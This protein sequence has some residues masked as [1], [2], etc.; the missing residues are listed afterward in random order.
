[1]QSTQTPRPAVVSHLLGPRVAAQSA[2]E[3]HCTVHWPEIASQI[4]RVPPQ[5]ALVTQSRQIP[6]P[7]SQNRAPRQ[8]SSLRQPVH[9]PLAVSQ[10]GK[11]AEQSSSLPHLALPA[12]PP[13]LPALPLAPFVPAVVPLDPAVP[14][15]PPVPGASS[16]SLQATRKSPSE[17]ATLTT[18]R[19]R[20]S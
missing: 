16:S 7:V 10:W 5:C 15:P 12:V 19:M 14:E 4:G 6:F 18:K 9:A 1:M 13:L 2:S 17:S 8:S 20:S 11:A 3:V